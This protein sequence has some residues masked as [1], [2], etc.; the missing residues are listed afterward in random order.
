MNEAAEEKIGAY[1]Y[2]IGHLREL[3]PEVADSYH[4]FTGECFRD[5][6]LSSREKQLIALGIS[7]FANNEVCTFLHVNEAMHKGATAQ[8]IMETVAVAGAIGGGH[9]LSQGVT[10]VQ[11]AIESGRTL[12]VS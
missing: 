10:R 7:L 12:P 5:G 1:K 2:G 11:K 9:S 6:A 3:L 4:Q 8:Q